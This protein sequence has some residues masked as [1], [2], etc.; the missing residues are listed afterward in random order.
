M[1]AEALASLADGSP[2]LTGGSGVAG[3]DPAGAPRWFQVIHGA[4]ERR[5]ALV[6]FLD[7]S[8]FL[9]GHAMAGLDDLLAWRA[10]PRRAGT[11]SPAGSARRRRLPGCAGPRGW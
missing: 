7:G 1:G 3:F 5:E 8:T 2:V 9:A 4:N 6:T 10:R 11:S